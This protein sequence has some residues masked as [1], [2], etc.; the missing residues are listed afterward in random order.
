MFLALEVNWKMESD[1][2]KIYH[3]SFMPDLNLRPD[4]HLLL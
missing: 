2:S 1:F 3:Y 4:L